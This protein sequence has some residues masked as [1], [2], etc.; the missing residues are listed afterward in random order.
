MPRKKPHDGENASKFPSNLIQKIEIE[1]E[2][3]GRIKLGEQ[4]IWAK[5]TRIQFMKIN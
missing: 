5:R 1:I 2:S 4:F 3:P